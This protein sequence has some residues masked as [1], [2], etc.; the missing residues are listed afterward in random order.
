MNLEK[1]KKTFYVSGMGIHTER[2]KQYVLWKDIE[3]IL[4]YYI[5]EEE[6]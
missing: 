6:K 1:K 3:E 2:P 4:D 5:K